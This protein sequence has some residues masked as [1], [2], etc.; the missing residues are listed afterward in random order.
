M[1]SAQPSDGQSENSRVLESREQAQAV[2][3]IF[4]STLNWRLSTMVAQP[5]MHWT[6]GKAFKN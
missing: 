5:Q 2:T 3:L 6:F 4:L 1:Y